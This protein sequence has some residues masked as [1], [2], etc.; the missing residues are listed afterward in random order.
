MEM[1]LTQKLFSFGGRIRRR[2]WWLLSIGLAVLNLIVQGI[3]GAVVGGGAAAASTGTDPGAAAAGAAGVAGIASLLIALLFLWPSLALSIKRAHDRNKP[4]MFV[5]G[6]Y[7]LVVLLLV[8]ITFTMGGVLAAAGAGGDNS[9]A[10]GAAAGTGGIVV[11]VLSVI[12]LV[13]AIWLLVELGFLDG[14]PGPNRF[15]PSPKGLGGS[16]EAFA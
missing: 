16:A 5:L 12:L 2:D 1:S 14:T 9:A 10:V 11:M 4:A 15:G 8:V 13:Y 7:A 3:V 6:Y